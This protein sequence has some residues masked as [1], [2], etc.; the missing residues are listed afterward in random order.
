MV[1]QTVVASPYKEVGARERTPKHKIQL[2]ATADDKQVK[3]KNARTNKES[4]A[5]SQRK[6]S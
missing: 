1:Q 3:T 5:A 2:E 4:K 6:W